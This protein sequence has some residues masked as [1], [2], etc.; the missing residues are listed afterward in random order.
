MRILPSY[1][2]HV[3]LDI[4]E[5]KARCGRKY[6]SMLF[7]IYQ[8]TSYEYTSHRTLDVADQRSPEPQG[9]SSL[10]GLELFMRHVALWEGETRGEWKL[11]Q[12]EWL[13]TY[14]CFHIRVKSYCTNPLTLVPRRL[15][16]LRRFSMVSTNSHFNRKSHICLVT[17]G[18]PGS[19]LNRFKTK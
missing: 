15:W 3:S 7:R 10:S 14:V 17:N 1:V 4:L 2:E 9:T 16:W 11:N 6:T 5:R 18:T 13:S 8:K 19:P 12:T